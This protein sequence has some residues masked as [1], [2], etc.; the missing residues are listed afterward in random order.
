MARLLEGKVAIITGSGRGIGRE[1]ALLMAKHGAMLNEEERK[2]LVDATSDAG[3]GKFDVIDGEVDAN[4]NK[5]ANDMYEKLKA[6]EAKLEEARRKRSSLVARQHAAEARQQMDKTLSN[7]EA[8]IKAQTQ[9]NRME[10][11]VAEMEAK[12][13]AIMELRDDRSQLE[14][15]FLDM[16]INAEIDEELRSL[17]SKI[18]GD[19]SD[20]T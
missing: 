18:S 16:E 7:F 13:D 1:E 12:T 3:Y 2:I 4:A 20:P 11:K 17:R 19:N 6:L 8:G 10:D 9:F 15:E 14:R 5:T